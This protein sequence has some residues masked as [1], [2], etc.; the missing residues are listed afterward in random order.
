MPTSFTG[1]AAV[2]TGASSGIGRQI[3][4]LLGAA[5]M[6]QWLVGRS[7]SGLE[8]TA[9]MIASA[10]GGK[11]HCEVIDLEQRGPIDALIR[12][13]GTVHP[14]F[15]A[16][17]NNAGIMHPESTLTGTMA[18][19]QAM[20]QVNVLAALEASRAAIEVMRAQGQP[21]RIVNISSLA[22]RFEA[23]GV[24]GASKAAL[25]MIA[26]TLRSEL[27]QDQIRVS[28]VVPGGFQTQLGRSL[29]PESIQLYIDIATRKGLSFGPQPD[30]RLLGD[31]VHVA[32]QVLHILEQPMVIDIQEIVVR[33][34]G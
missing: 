14:H 19:W 2:I 5:G 32:K 1:R 15:Y 3:A 6:E 22:A 18:R 27:E 11:T 12:H 4:L 20:F 9:A 13:I 7:K 26:R 17:I 8:E 23:G 30:E 29:E 31:P 21:G 10:A 25:E 24:Y 33:P 34:L 16:L 28:T